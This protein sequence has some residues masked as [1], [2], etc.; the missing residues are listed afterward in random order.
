MNKTKFEKSQVLFVK[1]ISL[2]LVFS[3]LSFGYQ[4]T[5][6]T[7]QKSVE[8]QNT[9]LAMLEDHSCCVQG[10]DKQNVRLKTQSKTEIS[11]FACQC[12]SQVL[13]QFQTSSELQPVSL[14]KLSFSP[15]SISPKNNSIILSSI[16]KAIP[17]RTAPPQARPVLNTLEK[18]LI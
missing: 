12:K 13:G 5:C 11:K 8:S 7:M 6:S 16:Y 1:A 10:E 4:P 9:P 17:K 18:L 3:V 2:L 15:E 14:T